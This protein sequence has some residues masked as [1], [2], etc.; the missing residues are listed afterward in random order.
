MNKQEQLQQILVLHDHKDSKEESNYTE[1][2][3]Y[4]MH[5]YW[6]ELDE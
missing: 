3:F 1:H 2:R 5:K 4:I 6:N